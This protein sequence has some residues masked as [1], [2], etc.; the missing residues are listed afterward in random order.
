MRT[1]RPPSLRTDEFNY[2]LQI[3]LAAAVGV[4]AALGNLGFRALIQFFTWLFLGLEWA[5]L[6]IDRGGWR[7][8]LVPIV[9]LSGGAGMILLDRLFPGDVLGYGF[10]NFLEMVNLGSARIKRRWIVLKALGAALSL[11]CGASVGREG[12]IAQIG[13]AIGSAVAQLRRLPA[14]RTKVLVAAGAA[15]GIATTFNAPVGGVLFAQEIVLLGETE[16]DHLTLLLVSTV[17]AVVFSRAI[18]GNSAVFYPPAFVMRSYWELLSYGLMGLLMGVLSANYIHFFHATAAA[19][20]AMKV[21]QWARLALGLFIVGLVAIVLPQNLSD[22]YPT[23][24]L[25][26]EG[27]FDL[28]MTL[29]LAA[30][31]FF[32]SSVS[33]GCGAPGGVFGPTFFIGTM[34]GATFQRTMAWMTPRLTG[35]RG[36][37]ALVGLGTFL[38]GVTHAPLTALFLLLDMTQDYQIAL[39]AMIAVVMALVVSR[40]L[41]RESIDTYRLAREGKTLDI[42]RQRLVLTQIPVE[43][44]MTHEPAVVRSNAMLS[45]VL[46]AAGNTPQTTLPVV[47]DAGGLMGIIVTRDLVAML[48]SQA[49]V[50]GLVNAYDICRRNGPVV[51]ADSNLDEAAQLMESEDLEELPVVEHAAGQSGHRLVGLVARKDITQV[52]NRMAVSMSTLANTGT[53]IFWATGY[54]LMRITVPETAQGKTMVELAPRARFGVSVLAVQKAGETDDGFVPITPDRKLDPGDTIMAAGRPSDLRRFV[55]ELEES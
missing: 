38:C 36:S 40:S 13:G 37:Y 39:P 47:D 26:M 32:T 44:S 7:L 3:L 2:T 20:R 45:E 43:S 14:D 22:G 17:S 4:L 24:N 31:K 29:A 12:P 19:F 28:G 16:L 54:R 8:G 23:I 35:P 18:T 9:L 52:L 30:A 15:A 10:P 48:S 5:A 50:A 51:S 34:A 49:D 55:R 21:P 1:I 42:G 41:E 33:L 25:A 46:Q 27:H 11:G 6:G 53:S